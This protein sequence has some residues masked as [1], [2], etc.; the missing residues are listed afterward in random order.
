MGT[1]CTPD[2]QGLTRCR[3]FSAVL[4]IEWSEEMLAVHIPRGKEV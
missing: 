3:L 4:K 1:A 2:Y